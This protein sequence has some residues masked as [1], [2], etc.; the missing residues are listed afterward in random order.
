MRGC[1]SEPSFGSAS[2]FRNFLPEL[3]PSLKIINCDG[4]LLIVNWLPRLHRAGL[5]ASL[6][7]FQGL[8]CWALVYHRVG[9][10]GIGKSKAAFQRTPLLPQVRRFSTGTPDRQGV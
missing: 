1:S 4:Q 10:E 6:D 9:R 2:S 7:E 8:S 5:S 3:A